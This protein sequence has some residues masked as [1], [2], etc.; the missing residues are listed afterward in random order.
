MNRLLPL[1]LL[2]LSV[3]ADAQSD[4][5][6]VVKSVYDEAL[7]DRTAYEQLGDFVKKLPEG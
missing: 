1:M 3:L 6:K 2:C 5:N 4:D 7:T